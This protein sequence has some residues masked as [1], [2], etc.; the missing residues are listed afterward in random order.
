MS[1]LFFSHKY[2]KIKNYF[3]FEL[4]KKKIEPIH[5][6][7]Y[8]KLLKIWVSDPGSRSQKG[9]GSRIHIRNTG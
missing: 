1:Y 4:R 6:E 2:Y 9:T 8:S 3:V 5:K 7:L